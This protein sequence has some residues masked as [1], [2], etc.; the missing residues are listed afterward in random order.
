MCVGTAVVAFAFVGP[1]LWPYGHE[2][3]RGIPGG[4]PPSWA[5]PFGTT[6]AGHDVLGQVMRGTQQSLKVALTVAL[7]STTIGALW[8]TV[9]GLYG[10]LVD[11]VM[12]RVVD[13]FQSIP[14]FIFALG[15][16]VV[17]GTSMPSLIGFIPPSSTS[18]LH[19]VG[20][21]TVY[22]TGKSG[23]RP[24]VRQGTTARQ[25]ASRLS[26]RSRRLL[27]SDLPGRAIEG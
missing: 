4:A 18:G 25:G 15:V 21:Q 5:H 26:P 12:M 20:M 13:V 3:Q 11:A 14:A 7:V 1:H 19:F 27:H 6:S 10:G 8:G 16:A 23:S 22:T 9:A 2:I 17:I 24:P